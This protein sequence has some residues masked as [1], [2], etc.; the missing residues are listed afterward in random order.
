MA[1]KTNAK[2]QEAEESNYRAVFGI[3]LDVNGTEIPISSD[4]ISNWKKN[5]LDFSLPQ[6]V[7]LG[8]FNDLIEW[9]STNFGVT[10]PSADDLPS[11]LNDM[12]NAITSLNFTVEQLAFKIPGTESTETQR[13]FTLRIAGSWDESKEIIP[14]LSVLKLKGGVFGVTNMNNTQAP[15]KAITISQI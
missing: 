2:I 3:V 10:I 13:T 7:H 15:D 12:V 8:S 14:G 6:P 4:N 1:K 11:P 5:G 9:L